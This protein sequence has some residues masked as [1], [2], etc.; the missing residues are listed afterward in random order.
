M[1]HR[2]SLKVYFLAYNAG[3]PLTVIPLLCCRSSFKKSLQCNAT[4]L[5]LNREIIVRVK[6]YL[7]D[8]K[9]F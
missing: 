8:F 6:L 5:Y 9:M 4:M 3:Q 7:K 2:V 1:L